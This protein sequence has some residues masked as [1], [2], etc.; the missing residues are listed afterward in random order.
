MTHCGHWP[1]FK[2]GLQKSQ[3]S[4]YLGTLFKSKLGCVGTSAFKVDDGAGPNE[5]PVQRYA[6]REDLRG[7]TKVL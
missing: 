3:S 5:H 4:S 6:G 2:T 1:K 7:N